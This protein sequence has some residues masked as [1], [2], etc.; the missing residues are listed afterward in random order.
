MPGGAQK[1]AQRKA[2]SESLP[3]G[4]SCQLLF[5]KTLLGYNETLLYIHPEKG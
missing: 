4:H 1:R 2:R 5:N 3:W